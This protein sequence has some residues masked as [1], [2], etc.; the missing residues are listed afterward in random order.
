MTCVIS[1]FIAI[2]RKS[3]AITLHQV[4]APKKIQQTSTTSTGPKHELLRACHP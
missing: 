4:F 2:H 3:P 1:A